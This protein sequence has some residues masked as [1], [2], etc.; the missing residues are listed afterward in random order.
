[1]NKI[2]NAIVQ[3]GLFMLAAAILGGINALIEKQARIRTTE[4]DFRR[5]M[6]DTRDYEFGFRDEPPE[7]FPEGMT[8]QEM[9]S[10]MA[11][12]MEWSETWRGKRK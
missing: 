12:I 1:M 11:G 4:K 2:K 9:N 5:W 10:K 3:T 6:N 8:R 7:I